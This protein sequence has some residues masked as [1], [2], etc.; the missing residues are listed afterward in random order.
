MPKGLRTTA[1]KNGK[2]TTF[3]KAVQ[4]RAEVYEAPAFPDVLFGTFGG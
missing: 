4:G 2:I 1:R 3:P